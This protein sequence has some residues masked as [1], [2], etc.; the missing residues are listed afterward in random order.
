MTRMLLKYAT[1]AFANLSHS[2]TAHTI[3]VSNSEGRNIGLGRPKKEYCGNI[4]GGM[5][6][7]HTIVYWAL[8][9][10]FTH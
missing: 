6:V 5:R 8:V 7:R 2:I 9:A 10:K 3:P 1:N 4:K